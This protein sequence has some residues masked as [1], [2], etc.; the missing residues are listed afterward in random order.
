MAV[1]ILKFVAVIAACILVAEL[2]VRYL[3]DE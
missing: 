2:V 1:E 3:I